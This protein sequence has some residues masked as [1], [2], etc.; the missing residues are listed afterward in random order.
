MN[1]TVKIIDKISK[2]KVYRVQSRIVLRY[3]W[4]YSPKLKLTRLFAT[5]MWPRRVACLAS[6]RICDRDFGRPVMDL[7]CNVPTSLFSLFQPSLLG[8]D[9]SEIAKF[10]KKVLH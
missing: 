5:T 9:G 1:P 3:A 6:F 10:R 4:K 7:H 2:S 8:A